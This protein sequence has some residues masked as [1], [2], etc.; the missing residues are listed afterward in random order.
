MALRRKPTPSSVCHEGPV[1][2]GSCPPP[3]PGPTLIQFLE[4]TQ[5]IPTAGPLPGLS[6]PP[7]A[8]LS[9]SLLFAGLASCHPSPSWNNRP[10]PPR[11]RSHHLPYCCLQRT[12]HTLKLFPIC[13]YLLATVHQN[14]YNTMRAGITS[15]QF[16]GSS[17]SASAAPIHLCSRKDSPH[18]VHLWTF[19]CCQKC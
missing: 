7:G 1:K 8:S 18:L 12:G 5:H 14:V 3:G 17:P 2:T 10:R 15:G 16:T 11:C 4:H 6:P 19:L 13:L 9:L